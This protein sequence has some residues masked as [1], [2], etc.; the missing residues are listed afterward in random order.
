MSE[1]VVGQRVWPQQRVLITGATGFIGR[2]VCRRLV[3]LGATVYGLSRTASRETV[4]TGVLPL[5]VD[6]TQRDAVLAA[7]EQAQPTHVLHLAAAGVNQPQLDKEEAT[8][9]NVNGTL[10]LLQAGQAVRIQRFVQVGTC[11]EHMADLSQ[12]NIYAA[13]KLE[14]WHTWRAFLEAHSSIEAAAVRLF[15]VYGPEQPAAGLIAAAIRAALGDE[16]FEMTPGEQVRDFVLIDDVVAA[17]LAALAA[18]LSGTETYDVGTGVGYSVRSV[19]RRIFEKVGGT[20]EAVVGARPYRSSEM[21]RLVADPQP[22]ARDLAWQA[23]MNLEAGL[24]MTIDWQRRQLMPWT[25]G[26]EHNLA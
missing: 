21:M 9:V 13:S 24:T 16:R 19:V 25:T 14:G 4:P 23:Q 26:L 5:S 15:H 8:R 3:T 1:R 20:G 12:S 22:A 10:H 6:V 2:Q 17:L 11:Y 18:P 7:L